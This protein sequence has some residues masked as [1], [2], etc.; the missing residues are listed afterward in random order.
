MQASTTCYL[1]PGLHRLVRL[2]GVA[3]AKPYSTYTIGW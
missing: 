1:F 3:T 2:Q